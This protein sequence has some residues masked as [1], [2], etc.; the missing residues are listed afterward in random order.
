[1][2]RVHISWL[3]VLSVNIPVLDTQQQMPNIHLISGQTHTQSPVCYFPREQNLGSRC[4]VPIQTKVPGPAC[5]LDKR[6]AGYAQR[7]NM[8]TL[9]R[10]Q[11][12]QKEVDGKVH[13]NLISN[14]YPVMGGCI[15]MFPE[16]QWEQSKICLR[17]PC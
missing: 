12:F 1:M 9:G 16:V 4:Q 2:E 14:E 7:I 11:T 17:A 13:S 5:Q 6:N 15:K 8:E 10:T 3:I